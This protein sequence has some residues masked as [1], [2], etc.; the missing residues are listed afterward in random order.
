KLQPV[1]VGDVAHAALKALQTPESQGKV[2]ELGGPRTYTYRT[3]IELLLG[4][5]QRRRLLL[6]LPFAI[7]KA[8]ALVGA[9]LPA[10]PITRAQVV[11]MERDNVV[12]K[13][14]SSFEELGLKPTALE[15]ILLQYTL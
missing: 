4:H 1:Y 10:P 12:A 15:D 7:W 5:M 3:L 14:A 9:I 11:L 13:S 6:P 8:L 2:Y